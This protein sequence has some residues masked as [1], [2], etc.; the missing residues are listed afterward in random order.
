MFKYICC[1]IY[2]FHCFLNQHLSTAKKPVH[3][4][5]EIKKKNFLLCW[6]MILK[7]G[8]A[9]IATKGKLSHQ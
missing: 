1:V 9:N 4:F 2:L 3:L 6:S 8:V 5:T 7:R